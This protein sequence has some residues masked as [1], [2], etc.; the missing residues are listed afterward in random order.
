MKSN[1]NIK[2]VFF[3][4]DDTLMDSSGTSKLAHMHA[5]EKM[6]SAGLP[7]RSVD[8]AYE[9]LHHILV[10]KGYNYNNHYNLLCRHYRVKIPERIIAAGMVAYHNTKFAFLRLFPDVM[11]TIMYLVKNNYR[12]IIITNGIAIKQWE[13]IVRLGIDNIIDQVYISKKENTSASKRS[14]GKKALLENKLKPSEVVWVGDRL[15]TDIEEANKLKIHSIR[16]LKGKRAHLKPKD[17]TQIP[18]FTINNIS[19]LP[20]ILR[21]LG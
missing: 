16:I 11:E 3:D 4:L 2:A 21:K 18:E 19:E 10:S 6:I 13:K 7:A 20:Q 17:A 14:L 9:Q 12:I 1:R 8:E 5:C 15:D